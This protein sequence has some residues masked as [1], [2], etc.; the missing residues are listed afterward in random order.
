MKM[1][2]FD[3]RS[4][5]CWWYFVWASY[6][7]WMM[8]MMFDMRSAQSDDLLG[9]FCDFWR[10]FIVISW[11]FCFLFF[12]F[13]VFCFFVFFFKYKNSPGDSLGWG[14]IM[15]KE[16]DLFLR[17]FEVFLSTFDDNDHFWHA[18]TWNFFSHDDTFFGVVISFWGFFEPPRW[19]WSFLP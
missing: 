11:V 17:C 15:S 10:F 8:M 7:S 13:F 1:I 2:I 14:A 9:I 19:K 6:A 16:D 5:Q 18:M 4:V 12:C 3:M